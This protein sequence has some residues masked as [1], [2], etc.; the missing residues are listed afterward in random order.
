MVDGQILEIGLNVLVH[1]EMADNLELEVAQILP[2][3]M[4]DFSALEVV[5]RLRNVYIL[6]G[7]IMIIR[8]GAGGD[9]N[10]LELHM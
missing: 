6:V 2:L 10:Y 1:V 8:G 5:L 3:L 9:Y 4:V 7:V